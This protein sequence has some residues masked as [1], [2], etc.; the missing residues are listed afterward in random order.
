VEELSHMAQEKMRFL[1]TSAVSP[2]PLTEEEARGLLDPVD[3]IRDPLHGDVRLTALE[4]SLMDSPEFQ[5]LRGINQLAMT[6]ISF[7]GALHNRFLHSLG[8]LHVCSQMIATCNTNADIY[9]RL[10]GPEDPVPLRINTYATLL[11]RL[12]ALLHD[13]A[14]VPFGHTLEKEGRVFEKDEWQDEERRE[15]LLLGP[16][17]PL[18][19][20]IRDFFEEIGLSA[21]AADQVREE[22]KTVLATKRAEANS[23]RY[24]FVHDLVGNTICADLV[25]YV[26]RDMYFC[27]LSERFGARFLEYL[28]VVPLIQESDALRP[29]R[30]DD[31]LAFPRLEY[32]GV[33]ESCRLVLL[34]Y[35]YNERRVPVTKHDVIAEAIDLVR[36]RLAVAEKLYFHRTKV[37]ASSMLVRAAYVAGL[38]PLDIWNLTD[39]E[40][41]KFLEKASERRA[42]ILAGKLRTRKLFKPIY[43]ASYHER[44]E[45][46]ASTLLWDEDTGAY[47]RFKNPGDREELA[48]KLENLIGLHQFRDAEKAVGSICIS[49]PD[50]DMNLKAFDMLVLPRPGATVRRLQDSGYPPTKIEIEAIL[51]MH[52]HLWR[53]EVL[54]D[55]EAV[56][57]KVEDPFTRRLAGA[58]QCEIGP[59]N[60]IEGLGDAPA[61]ELDDWYH[62]LS[63][64]RDLEVLGVK[65]KVTHAHFEELKQG[66]FRNLKPEKR[67]DAIREFLKSTG[68]AV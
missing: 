23:L 62:E 58:I 13:L 21:S 1:K 53:L 36:R 60:E 26:Q 20:R 4:R 38:K 15:E 8:T 56:S 50:A 19:S 54:V 65:E 18:A 49:C 2:D 34:Q 44:D 29:D 55:P 51:K 42:Q 35:R 12:C 41:L 6:Y 14:H 67:M 28:A 66:A 52:K 9:R 46:H 3:V 45:S 7:P 27:G 11:A 30:R 68:Y 40:V 33:V 16:G 63:I 57:L 61:V 39:A 25:D 32:D 59:K 24:P 10:A 43:R 31:Q 48:T 5:R 17:T 22:V 37:I 47:K 64:N